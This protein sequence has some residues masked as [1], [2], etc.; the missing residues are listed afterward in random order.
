MPSKCKAINDALDMIEKEVHAVDSHIEDVKN[1]NA[2]PTITK[3]HQKLEQSIKDKS[4]SIKN[5]KS[6]MKNPNDIMSEKEMDGLIRKQFKS[7]EER[8]RVTI[9]HQ[10]RAIMN[11][12]PEFASFADEIIL[13]KIK[14]LQF[15][16]LRASG[17]PVVFD[18]LT[19]KPN[20]YTVPLESLRTI[21]YELIPFMDTSEDGKARGLIDSNL[22]FEF[23]MP[24]NVIMSAATK[25]AVKFKHSLYRWRN[26]VNRFVSSWTGPIDIDV[27]TE[28][29]LLHPDT[30]LPILD[31]LK[32]SKAGFTKIYDI[33]NTDL[34]NRLIAGHNQ[35]GESQIRDKDELFELITDLMTNKAFIVDSGDDYGKVYMYDKEIPKGE[36]EGTKD[37]KI[38]FDGFEFTTEQKEKI[39]KKT[40]KPFKGKRY[41]KPYMGNKKLDGFGNVI[42]GTGVHIN[43]NEVNAG[44]KGENLTLMVD[45]TLQHMDVIFK[46]ILETMQET[47]LKSQGRW[48]KI[49]GIFKSRNIEMPQELFGEA[50]QIDEDLIEVNAQLGRGV[51]KTQYR[52]DH[53]L[54]DGTKVVATHYS[55]YFPRMYFSHDLAE[56]ITLAVENIDNEIELLKLQMTPNPD[57]TPEEQKVIDNASKRRLSLI[58]SKRHLDKSLDKMR[59]HGTQFERNDEIPDVLRPFE[60]HFKAVGHHIPYNYVRTDKDVPTSYAKRIARNLVRTEMM[61]DMLEVYIDVESPTYRRYLVN[62]YKKAFGDI[63]SEGSIA[64]F[65]FSTRDLAKLAPGLSADQLKR[66]LTAMR[67]LSVFNNLSGWTTGPGNMAAHINKMFEVGQ[68]KWDEAFSDAQR[69]ENQ[70]RI[71]RSGVLSFEDVIENHIMINGNPS[72]QKN[73]KLMQKKWKS[74]KRKAKTVSDKQKAI[75]ILHL[76][77]KNNHPIM[78]S[79]RTLANWAITGK[80]AI[81]I[82]N[83]GKIKKLIKRVLNVKAEFLPMSVS[84]KSVRMTSFQ[85]GVNQAVSMWGVSKDDPLAIDMGI[86]FVEEL[87]FSLGPEGVGDLFG[88]DL[89]QWL[90]H[91]RIWSTQRISYGKDAYKDAWNSVR[92]I[93]DPERFADGFKRNTEASWEFMKALMATI[94]GGGYT[95]AGSLLGVA[96]KVLGES[97]YRGSQNLKKRSKALRLKNNA[98]QKGT[99]MFLFHGAMSAFYDLVIFNAG[100]NWGSLAGAVKVAKWAG[101]KTGAHKFGPA[102]TSPFLRAPIM[103]MYMLFKASSE[104]DELDRHDFMKLFGSVA[105]I[106][107]MQIAYLAMSTMD[108]ENSPLKDD[109]LKQQL[110]GRQFDNT[111]FPK[112]I[113]DFGLEPEIIRNWSEDQWRKHI[114]SMPN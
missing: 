73:F 106:G 64:S 15:D 28:K 47:L 101:W 54:E 87:D 69:P 66:F 22:A 49:L 42:E 11:S 104:D 31:N 45:T 30:K 113:S 52:K 24:K 94:T 50:I 55:R 48:K 99:Q 5:R 68:E 92:P 2:D 40:G 7:K 53:Y 57:A 81:D 39:E 6:T 86:R 78:H 97:A 8:E 59:T 107:W 35:N 80:M 32:R 37:T 71:I 29:Q 27:R 60:K 76:M 51:G 36:W 65:R 103:A 75:D 98:M 25:S 82:E 102:F 12:D 18:D 72:E 44:E 95:I 96:S 79:I 74:E 26:K 109:K 33:L 4:E 19:S 85:I 88:N 23:Y 14:S 20:L 90:M 62:Q 63:D 17:S 110:Y 38:D 58:I 83:D 46:E 111:F 77:K 10:I 89:T 84:E 108:D 34:W 43:L 9:V 21:Y 91:V 70:Q 13:N 105:G 61:L 67:S 41:I 1:E 16:E 114:S 56:A 3:E 112:A 100:V 93:P